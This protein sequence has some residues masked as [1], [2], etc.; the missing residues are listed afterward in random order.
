MKI[1]DSH[2]HLFPETEAWAEEKARL[3]GHEN[4]IEHLRSAYEAAGIVHGVVMGNHGLDVSKYQYPKDLFHYCAGIDNPFTDAAHTTPL[5]GL[6]EGVEE[7]L[8]QEACCG[9]KL[10]PGYNRVW[11]YDPVYAPI[12]DLCARYDKPVAVHMGLTA[13]AVESSPLHLNI[14]INIEK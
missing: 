2:L 4:S 3:V 12:Y 14:R 13:M 9:I 8:K 10:Y 1:I 7:N 11:L 5:P 6:Y